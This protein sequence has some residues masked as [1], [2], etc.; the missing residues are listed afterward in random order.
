MSRLEA[1]EAEIAEVED[2]LSAPAPSPV[3][4]HPNVSALYRKRVAAL[5]ASLS[6]PSIRR[7]AL[8]LI[9]SLIVRVTVRP[10]VEGVDL[11]LEGALSAMI[12]VAQNAESRLSAACSVEVVA[13]GRSRRSRHAGTPKAKTS[14]AGPAEAS[15]VSLVAG[16]RNSRFLRLVE[17]VV[18]MLAA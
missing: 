18:P 10:G 11:E 15:Q 6:E 3:L 2:Q 8:E 7:R 12:G 5:S 1:L 9:R 14:A 17:R 16:A 4:L 13:G